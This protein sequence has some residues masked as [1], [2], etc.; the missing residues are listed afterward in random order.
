MHSQRITIFRAM[1]SIIG[2]VSDGFGDNGI[3]WYNFMFEPVPNIK[4]GGR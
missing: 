1:A 2:D 3:V 4:R